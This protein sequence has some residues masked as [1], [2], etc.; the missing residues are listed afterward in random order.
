MH[1]CVKA[2]HLPDGNTDGNIDDDEPESEIL[3]A[4]DYNDH[5]AL[6]LACLNGHFQVVSYLCASG[7]DLEARYVCQSLL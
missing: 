5:T 6:H 4:A 2:L 3:N 1:S 7:A